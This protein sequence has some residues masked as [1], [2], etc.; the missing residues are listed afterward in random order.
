MRTGYTY[1][2]EM[3][4]SQGS[5]VNNHRRRPKFTGHHI[6]IIHKDPDTGEIIIIPDTPNEELETD[7]TDT[8]E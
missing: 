8:N 5:Y 7:K 4:S 6:G 2:D 1:D 3:P